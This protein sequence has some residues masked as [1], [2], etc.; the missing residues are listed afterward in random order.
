MFYCIWKREDDNKELIDQ[1][2]FIRS[3]LK[4]AIVQKLQRYQNGKQTFDF[5]LL[6]IETTFG[7]YSTNFDE[8]QYQRPQII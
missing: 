5:Q 4:N 6:I 7:M 2:I 3:C 8:K 1:L